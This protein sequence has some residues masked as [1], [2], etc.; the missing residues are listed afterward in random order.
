MNKWAKRKYLIVTDVWGFYV[1]LSKSKDIARWV[2]T[3]TDANCVKK[4]T[5]YKHP[6]ESLRIKTKTAI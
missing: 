6:D 3:H 2:Y 4:I 5:L 1:T